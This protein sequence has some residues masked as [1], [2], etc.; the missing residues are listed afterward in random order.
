MR[1]RASAAKAPIGIELRVLRLA[2]LAVELRRE[3]ADQIVTIPG[4]PRA[5][6]ACGALFDELGWGEMPVTYSGAGKTSSRQQ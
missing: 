6:D 3:S 2:A 4:L 1:R 5:L